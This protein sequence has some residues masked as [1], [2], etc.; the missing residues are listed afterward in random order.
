MA[1]G[2]SAWSMT[3]STLKRTFSPLRGVEVTVTVTP[4]LPSHRREYR[5]TTDRPIDMADGGFAIPAEVDGVPYTP[6][7]VELTGRGVAARF[8]WGLSAITCEEGQCEPLL[9]K[10]YP[11]TNLLH[12]LTRIPTLRF[13]LEAGTHR[14][15]TVVTGAPEGF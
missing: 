6:D 12:P 3:D 13:R 9:V 10:A 4:G 14:V 1:R 5:I 7:M 8:P 15:V 2:F 11:N